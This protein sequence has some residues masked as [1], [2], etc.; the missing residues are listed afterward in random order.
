MHQTMGQFTKQSIDASNTWISEKLS[1]IDESISWFIAELIN[2]P[3]N[4]FMHELVDYWS[5]QSVDESNND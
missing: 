3:N 5:K 1:P 4:Q 2:K